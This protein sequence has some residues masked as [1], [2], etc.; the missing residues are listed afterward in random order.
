MTAMLAPVT[1]VDP[2]CSSLPALKPRIW[3]PLASVPTKPYV[4]ASRSKYTCAPEVFT[5]CFDAVMPGKLDP[6]RL[7]AA[8]DADD[9]STR[10]QARRMTETSQNWFP[11]Q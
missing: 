8:F 11:A 6:K 7:P 9:P 1:D 3:F 4:P 10:K 5:R 2:T